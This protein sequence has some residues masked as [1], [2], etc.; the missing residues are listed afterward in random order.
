MLTTQ[1]RKLEA[2][3]KPVQEKTTPLL[4]SQMYTSCLLDFTAGNERL[5]LMMLC[6]P[7]SCM[8]VI[9]CTAYEKRGT[10]VSIESTR[11]E[12]TSRNAGDVSSS[13][14]GSRQMKE[15]CHFAPPQ[16]FVFV[17]LRLRH[18]RLR[19]P[20]FSSAYVVIYLRLRLSVW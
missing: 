16:S 11:L 1:S 17:C 7:F 2:A 6:H 9:S 5:E 8:R 12:S 10:T 19:P 20:T 14:W 4:R 3:G 15:S 13:V 18:L